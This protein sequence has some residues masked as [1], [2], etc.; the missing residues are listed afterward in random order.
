MAFLH[1]TLAAICVIAGPNSIARTTIEPDSGKN[2]KVKYIPSE[3]GVFTITLLWN[4]VEVECKS[5]TGFT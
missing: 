1:C 3:V 2:W 5:S 4:D